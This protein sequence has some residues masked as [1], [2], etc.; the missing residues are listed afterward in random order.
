MHFPIY[1][2]LQLIGKMRHWCDFGW[3]LVYLLNLL[4]RFSYG[5]INAK[6]EISN[7]H[8]IISLSQLPKRKHKLKPQK[9]ATHN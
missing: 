6:T 1:V 9:Q 2:H 8:T 5:C 7:A 3:M 4:I